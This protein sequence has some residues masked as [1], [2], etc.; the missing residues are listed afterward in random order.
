VTIRIIS[1]DVW[2]DFQEGNGWH[3]YGPGL[4]ELEDIIWTIPVVD[5]LDWIFLSKMA[6]DAIIVGAG[7][8][9]VGV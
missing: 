8:A 9:S 5:V 6:V 3:I 1:L 7:V 4:D 2:Y